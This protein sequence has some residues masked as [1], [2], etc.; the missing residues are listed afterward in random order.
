LRITGRGWN[1][2][3]EKRI[4]SVVIPEGRALGTIDSLPSVDEITRALAPIVK[5]GMP[6]D[7]EFSDERL[8]GLP[9]VLSRSRDPE[10]RLSNVTA[11][12]ELIEELLDRFPDD[13]RKE[14]AAILFGSVEGSRGKPIGTRRNTAAALLG[15]T[16]EHV[17]TGI[18]REIVRKFAWQLHQDAQEYCVEGTQAALD[19]DWPDRPVPTPG[20]ES[21]TPEAR[22]VLALAYRWAQQALVRFEAYDHCIRCGEDIQMMLGRP[23]ATEVRTVPPRHTV[24]SDT[25]LWMNAYCNRYLQQLQYFDGGRVYLRSKQPRMTEF[26][27]RNV[28][29]PHAHKMIDRIARAMS[30]AEYDERD[31]FVAALR[32]DREGEDI[33]RRWIRFLTEPSVQGIA[34]GSLGGGR[35]RSADKRIDACSELLWLC[36]AL[37]HAAPEETLSSMFVSDL[38][39]TLTHALMDDCLVESRVQEGSDEWDMMEAVI[40]ENYAM[41]QDRYRRSRHDDKKVVWRIDDQRPDY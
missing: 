18:Q 37:Q 1:F 20:L 25:A 38:F 6:V 32:S 41:R 10:D 8:L 7:S 34:Y 26:A 16:S 35:D 40:Q 28:G 5:K 30:Q 13:A 9:N 17:R 22:Q 29:F 27:V 31:A 21:V 24:V 19:R 39:V 36:N 4:H 11:L 12:D 23:P 14:V 2:Y 15:V 3:S 33:Y